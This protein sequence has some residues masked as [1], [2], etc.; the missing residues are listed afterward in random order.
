VHTLYVSAYPARDLAQRE[1]PRTA[2]GAQDL[3]AIG[4]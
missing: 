1:R 4:R 2:H 3:E